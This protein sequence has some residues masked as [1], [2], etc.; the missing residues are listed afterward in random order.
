[1]DN[2]ANPARPAMFWIVCGN[3]TQ[4]FYQPAR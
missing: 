3:C 4:Q 1:M 2:S